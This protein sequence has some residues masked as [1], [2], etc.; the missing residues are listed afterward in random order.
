M[1][2]SNQYWLQDNRILQDQRGRYSEGTFTFIFT[3]AQTGRL[4]LQPL[5]T[6]ALQ[7]GKKSNR[8]LSEYYEHDGGRGGGVEG[9]GC[10]ERWGQEILTGF[11]SPPGNST[12]PLMKARLE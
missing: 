7:S 12:S 4:S 8:T 9:G 2:C 1:R 11:H 5:W 3:L 6:E 10:V